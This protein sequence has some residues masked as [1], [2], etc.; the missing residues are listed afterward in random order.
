MK[1]RFNNMESILEKLIAGLSKATDQHQFNTMTQSL[2]SSGV[3]KIG[4]EETE[5]K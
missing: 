3:L 2:F 4:E 5:R 1:K